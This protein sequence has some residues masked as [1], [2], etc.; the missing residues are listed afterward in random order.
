M[1]TDKR[2][3][4]LNLT[5]VLILS[6]LRICGSWLNPIGI[7][8]DWSN[9]ELAGGIC[10]FLAT[11]PQPGLSTTE[12]PCGYAGNRLFCYILFSVMLLRIE[13]L[14]PPHAFNPSS[15]QLLW[16]FLKT[17]WHFWTMGC[18]CEVDGDDFYPPRNYSE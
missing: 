3:D 8:S 12:D 10:S 5:V 4:V 6:S 15:L 18:S 14:L 7:G 13:I 2:S 1:L 17:W 11:E 16:E 9:L